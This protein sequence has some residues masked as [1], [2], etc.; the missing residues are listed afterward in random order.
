MFTFMGQVIF[1]SAIGVFQVVLISAFI[2]RLK[3]YDPV[4]VKAEAAAREKSASNDL[5]RP[6]HWGVILFTCLFFFVPLALGIF[7]V[8]DEVDRQALVNRGVIVKGEVTQTQ[9]FS[10]S[11][12]SDSG[13]TYTIYYKFLPDNSET[14][15]ETADG[16]SKKKYKKTDKGEKIKVIYDPQNPANNRVELKPSDKYGIFIWMLL[17]LPCVLVSGKLLWTWFRKFL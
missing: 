13:P 7:A 14:I 12:G 17:C 16:V 10:R 3:N 8:K 2:W 4:R 9:M 11:P 5:D 1:F 15:I 6:P